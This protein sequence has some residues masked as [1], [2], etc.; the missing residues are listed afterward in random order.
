MPIASNEGDAFVEQLINS[1][2]LLIVEALLKLILIPP[3]WIV[4]TLNLL[5]RLL[6]SRVLGST[7]PIRL[8]RIEYGARPE[9]DDERWGLPG[10]MLSDYVG[11]KAK[12]KV[13]R[14]SS[15]RLV[16]V[17]TCLQFANGNS[18]LS[19][20]CSG[21]VPGSCSLVRAEIRPT[22][23]SEVCEHEKID[24]QQKKSND[25]QMI[26]LKRELYDE[27]LD[28]QSKSIGTET[29][30]E[31]MAMKSKWDLRGPS[32]PKVTV[33]L[34]HFKRKTLCA[35]LDS[36]LH[37]TLPFHHV[38][39]LSF[40]SPNE[41]SLKR[42]VDSYNDSRIS[43]IS[44]SYD[45]KY[46]GRFQMALQTEAD[47]ILSHVA[48]TEKYKNS[49]L[50]S[51]GR[52]LPFRQKDFTFPSYRKFRS[53]EAGLYL[54]DPAYDITIEK[55]V[56][57]DFLSSSWFLSAELVKTLFI[58]AP[59][60]FMTGEDLHLSHLTDMIIT[61]IR[62]CGKN[63]AMMLDLQ[64]QK[65]RNAGSFVLPVDPNDKETWGDSEHRLAYVSETT[66]IFKDIVQVRD[67]QWWRALSTGYVTQWAAMHP[68][69]IDALFYAH[70]V[71]EVKALS[72]LSTSSG[73][74][75]AKRR[76]LLS[77]EAVSALVKM[78]DCSELAKMVCK[79]RRFKI[80]DLASRR[81]QKYRTRKCRWCRRLSDIDPNVKKALKMATETNNNGTTMVLLPRPSISKVLWMADLRS[82]AL[83]NWNKMRV[84][85]NIITQNRA[86]SLTRLLKSLSDAYYVGDEIPIS[87]NVDSK[88]DEETIRLVSSFNWPHGPKTLRRRIIQEADSSGMSWY[89]SSDDDYGLLLEDDI[90]VSPFYYLW[91]KY[92]L[93]AYH[94]DPQVSLPELSSI[95]LYTPR[96]VEVVKERPKWNATDFFKRV[97]PNTP[98]LHQLPCSWGSVFFPKQWREF[99]V[100][101]NM[102]FTEDAKAN[103][104]QIPKSRTNGWQA[105]WKKFLIDMMAHISAKD[106][107]VK[108]DKTDFEVPL[109]KEDFRSFLPNG[110]F[111]PA[112]KLPSLNLF[113]Q[114]VS[115]K[116][117]KAAGAKLGQ[118]VLRCDQATEI[119]SVDHETDQVEEETVGLDSKVDT[120]F[121][122]RFDFQQMKDLT[123]QRRAEMGT[124]HRS[125]VHRKTND[126]AR[127]IV[128][129]ILGVA[130][131]FFVGISFPAATFT[132]IH[133]PSSFTSSLKLSIVN[134]NEFR[135]SKSLETLGS[136]SNVTNIYVPTN[137][138]GAELLPPG[139]VVAESDFNL[140][141]LWGEPSEFSDDFQILLFH[142]DGRTSEWTSLSGQK[143]QFM[144]IEL[145]KKHG[146]EISQ[147][148]LEPDNGLTWQM[149]KRRGDREVHKDTEEKP[150][151]CS[152][153]HLPPCAA[154]VEIMAPVFSRE[155]WRC[156]W[157][158]IQ[159]D[160]VHGWGLDFALRRCVEPAHE[161]IGVVDSQWIIHQVIPSLGSQ[162]SYVL[163]RSENSFGYSVVKT[164]SCMNAG[165]CLT[166]LEFSVKCPGEVREGK[167]SMGRDLLVHPLQ[168]RARCRNEWSLFRSR[169]ADAEQAYLS[170]TK[171]G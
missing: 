151:W 134:Q 1:A 70:S 127:L 5:H 65:Y 115:L 147:P 26:K 171:K 82:T 80:F 84:S 47:L 60:T 35:Q 34:N 106:N 113:N 89:P 46:Y 90:E 76:T 126:S 104:V 57:V 96:L 100:Y 105:S 51:I 130:F 123:V 137:P 67:D 143:V 133:I 163:Y 6:R 161:K 38:W 55:I 153:P 48:G 64:L 149:T 135:R 27:V 119:V 44:S 2:K 25:A 145:V 41:L 148:G 19:T 40:G 79:E 128:V 22:N 132:K 165:A 7:L 73:L 77:L 155:A 142:Y 93:L 166:T 54:P 167:S 168:V 146:L 156:V 43:F 101:M 152:N 17:L 37:Q 160:L 159:N 116:G 87:F 107:V 59:L 36:L 16:T 63:G 69:K 72:P 125:G 4:T 29:L 30:S 102:R 118:D 117:L 24:F 150:G 58:E 154:F 109:L 129:T 15:A 122:L 136:G 49:V 21:S 103:P 94:Y 3:L 164:T 52:I 120:G 140:R 20:P 14:S 86:P 61:K 91:I 83:P 32:K 45:F 88:V 111:P 12:P 158:M 66:V 110:K 98:Y 62:N 68:Q 42:I 124:I 112:S 33:I 97:H 31:L 138:R 39:V 8:A 99:Y 81:R 95:S 78:R 139:I 141:R 92:A 10:G 131:G 169:L 13:P 162:I 74:L 56:Q 50:G 28:F 85:V 18:S 170:Q 114:P 9:F 108:H 144:Y 53:K 11:G 75:P 71:D 157:H 23:P 121:F